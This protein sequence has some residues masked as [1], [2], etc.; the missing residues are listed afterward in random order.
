MTRIAGILIASFILLATGCTATAPR[1]EVVEPVPPENAKGTEVVLFAMTLINTRYRFGGKNPEA[2][3][4][5]SGMVSYI[6][7]KAAGYTLKG[8]ASE[9]AK[10]GR[11]VPLE[12]AQPGDLVFFNTRNRPRSHVGIYIGEDKFVHAPSKNGRVKVS[13]LR[14]KY[15]VARFEETRRYLD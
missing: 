7:G 2:G 3:F 14:N 4:D 11:A 10:Q 8:S 12:Q 1:P 6:Y 13:S 5:C 15:F 9:M